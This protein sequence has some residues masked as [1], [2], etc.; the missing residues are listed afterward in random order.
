MIRVNLL[1]DAKSKKK[2]SARAPITFAPAG[3]GVILGLLLGVIVLAA[4]VQWYRYNKLVAVGVQMDTEIAALQREK[5][6]LAQV[7]SQYDTFSKRKELLTARINVIEQLKSQQAGPVILLN[8]LAGAVSST[9][10]LWLTSFDKVKDKLTLNGT[11][12]SM[13]AV[14]DLMTRLQASK[15]F[16]SVDLKET[17]QDARAGEVETFTFAVDILFSPP[18]AAANSPARPGA[19][20]S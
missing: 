6:E 2:R 5:A 16:R 8:T 19:P 11:A 18:A 1:G 9:D 10:T 14:A 15:Q 13:R 3:G 17:S 20:A 4:A 12:L 7:Q